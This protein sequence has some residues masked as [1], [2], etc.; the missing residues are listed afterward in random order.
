M[1]RAAVLSQGR[2]RQSRRRQSLRTRDAGR[3]PRDGLESLGSDVAPTHLANPIVPLGDS[4]QRGVYCCQLSNDL[5]VNRD[6]GESL[7]GD[8]RA[9]ADPL[10]ER[11]ATAWHV[12]TRSKRGRTLF[13]IVTQRLERSNE[14]VP[15]GQLIIGLG[16][17]C[18]THAADCRSGG[19]ARRHGLLPSRS[20]TGR[21]RSHR[22]R[23]RGVRALRPFSLGFTIAAPRAVRARRRHGRENRNPS[24]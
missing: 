13:E 24:T 21:P 1:T 4:D 7:D 3:R 10:A 17:G 18:R 14:F 22:R 5:I 15:V 12:R 20:R 8:A 2:I 16:C 11:N 23:H 6:I 19:T 9:L